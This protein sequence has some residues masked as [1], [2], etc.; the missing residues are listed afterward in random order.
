MLVA[1][2][3]AIEISRRVEV[4]NTALLYLALLAALAL[5]WLVPP[6]ALLPL[7]L[8]L[9]FA[10]ATALTF[11]P[12]LIANLV[13]AQRFRNVES[14]SVAFGANLLGAMLGGLAEYTALLIGYRNLV[15]LVAI[16]YA[17]AWLAGY[18]HL[19]VAS[20]K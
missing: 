1:V 14:S 6:S 8:P 20:A 18:R 15:I 17:G 9:R 2:L 4:R 7:A 3:I 5:A 12:I 10:A 13:F 16:L 11:T 19:A